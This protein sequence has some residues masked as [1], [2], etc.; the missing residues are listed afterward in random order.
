MR[1][2]FFLLFTLITSSIFSQKEKEFKAIITLLDKASNDDLPLEQRLTYS[3]E[4]Y[5]KS[6][7]FK[8]DSLLLRSGKSLSTSYL[9]LG[10][11]EEYGAINHKNLKL[12]KK[13]KDTSIIAY[14]LH[15]LGWYHHS[16]SKADS[17]YYYY[18]K[19]R[20]IYHQNGDALNESSVLVNMVNIQ[21]GEKD[22]IGGEENAFQAIKLLQ[23]LDNQTEDV[24]DSL[25]SLNNTLGLISERLQK[26]EEAIEYYNKSIEISKKMENSRYYYLNSINN[27]GYT[28]E[29]QGDLNQALKLYKEVADDKDLFQ[30][31]AELYVVAIGNVARINFLIDKNNVEDSKKILFKTLKITDSIDDTIGKMG[32]YGFLADIYNTTSKKDSALSYSKLFYRLAKETSSNIER[33]DALKL[34]AELE[35]GKKGIAYLTEH[36]KL[37]D[38]LIFK[39]RSIKDRFAR[40]EFE[41]DEIEAENELISKRNQWLIGLSGGLLLMSLLVYI[42]ISQRAKN[43]EL[44]FVQQQQEANEEIYNLMLEQQNKVDEGRAKE[45]IRIS[46]ELHDGVLSRLFGIRLSLDSINMVNTEEAIKNRGNYINEL[47]TIE[48]EIR[49]ISHDLNTDFIANLGFL[50]IIETLIETQTSAYQLTYEFEHSEIIDWDEVSNKNKIHLYRIIQESLQNIY[51]HANASHVKI[52]FQLKNDVILVSILD[53]GSGFDINKAKKGIGLKNINSRVSELNGELTINSKS[54]RGTD[55]LINV[56]I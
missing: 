23:G 41:T 31:D 53:D 38:S 30:F 3:L 7:R 20:E 29:Q 21:E 32:I 51:K 40:I 2:L 36:I 14:A 13:I 27:L 42:I 19:A 12:A 44:R 34:M 4:A 37:N 1:F 56:P 46:E 55:I 45:K 52:G 24:L 25:W 49:K 17:A 26:R 47:K 11:Y 16:E 48:Q 39:E 22:Y 10:E 5:N 35:G 9:Y 54:G 6:K 8:N 28:I 33:L 15:N 50:D 18:Y 43:K